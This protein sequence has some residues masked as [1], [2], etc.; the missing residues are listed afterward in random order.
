M[1][2]TTFWFPSINC[3][4]ASRLSISM[5]ESTN[6]DSVGEAWIDI[7]VGEKYLK[8]S[9]VIVLGLVTWKENYFLALGI[10]PYPG[11]A[12]KCTIKLCDEQF[13]I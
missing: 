3:V 7:N 6:E 10:I 4:T 5:I 12:L 13:Y 2:F 1:D 8:N 9:I 11:R